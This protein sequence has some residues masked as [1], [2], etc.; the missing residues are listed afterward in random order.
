MA[1]KM[2]DKEVAE[3]QG[4]LLAVLSQHIGAEKAIGMDALFERVFGE[5]VSH[6]INDTR[7]LRLLVTALREQGVAIC[8]TCR[9]N[10]GGY[11]LAR[12]GSELED[13]CGRLHKRALKAL[14]LESKVR[15]VSLPE[16]LGQMRLR[17]DA[18]AE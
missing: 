18:A 12:A 1:D 3:R 5:P 7:R 14:V 10:S 17:L 9:Q 15:Q 2:K 11:Y 13:Y 16:L 4:V 6:K 8:S